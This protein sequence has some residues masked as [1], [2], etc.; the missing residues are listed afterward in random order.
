MTRRLRLDL[1]GPRRDERNQF[2]LAVLILDER[3]TASLDGRG[4]DRKHAVGLQRWMGD[5]SDMPKLQEDQAAGLV[6]RVGYEAPALD[7]FAA[8]NAGRPGIALSL[9]RHLGRLRHDESRRGPLPV[10]ARVEIVRRVGTLG[11]PVAGQGGHHEPVVQLKIAEL[12]GRKKD[13][14]VMRHRAGSR[15]S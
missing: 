1:Q 8:V 7:L 14:G 15:T 9:L 10:I 2:P 4:R 5:A 6:H 11:R 12:K 13:A 3:L